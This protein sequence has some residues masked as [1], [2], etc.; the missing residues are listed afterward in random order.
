MNASVGDRVEGI[1]FGLAA[2]DRNGGPVRMAVRLAESL[3][4]RQGFDP[5]DIGR[6]YLNWWRNGAF[7]TGPVV[8]GVLRLV[9]GG[10][11]FG[12]AAAQ[13]NQEM[14]GFTAG[15]NPAHRCASLAMARTLADDHIHGVARQ[16][17]AL[18]HVNPLAG[19][20]SAAVALLCRLLV[21]G[22]SWSVALPSAGKALDSQVQASLEAE[23]GKEPRLNNGGYSPDVLAAAVHFLDRATSFGEALER[24]IA[25]AGPANY[26]PVLVGSIGGAR[27]GRSAIPK[28]ML[29]HCEILDQVERDV[30]LLS[31]GW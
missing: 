11:T 16:E 4:E 25:F 23:R 8:A 20:T 6:R 1:L 7:D 24:A 30:G 29:R 31:A 21:N 22:E 17:A 15:C 12:D 5:A 14:G 27:W 26:C 19:G 18:T 3:A 28:D 2:G 13:I 10:V 9:N